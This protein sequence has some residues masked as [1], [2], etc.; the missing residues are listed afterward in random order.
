MGDEFIIHGGQGI[1]SEVA[2]VVEENAT[3]IIETA[4]RLLKYASEILVT[5]T[6]GPSKAGIVLPNRGENV[7]SDIHQPARLGDG[8]RSQ[9]KP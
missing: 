3:V 7:F 8:Q 2:A 5:L 4:I 9:S 1:R 6:D